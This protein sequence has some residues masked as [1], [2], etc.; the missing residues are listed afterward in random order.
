MELSDQQI[1]VNKKEILRLLVSTQREGVERVIDY[2]YS[3]GV[4]T[5]PSLID[6]H[7]CWKGGLAEH[8]LNVCHR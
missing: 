5:I 1:D 8:S 2:R 6:R 3:S 4:F 7:H